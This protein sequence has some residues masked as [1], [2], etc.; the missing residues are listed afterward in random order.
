MLYN[1]KTESDDQQ[2]VIDTEA[3]TWARASSILATPSVKAAET[4]LA[5]FAAQEEG[6][7]VP[8]GQGVFRFVG[9][10]EE[11]PDGTPNLAIIAIFWVPVTDRQSSQVIM[12]CV[13]QANVNIKDAK[14]QEIKQFKTECLPA[15]RKAQNPALR[16]IVQPPITVDEQK[17]QAS[18][19][20][21]V[22]APLPDLSTAV[23][24]DEPETK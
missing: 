24:P 6:Q 13:I 23:L 18:T 9:R 4:G 15:A 17:A 12:V 10:Q 22:S 5:R 16:P 19:E 8:F 7:L 11:N 2:W 20:P 14:S 21:V 3:L 1:F